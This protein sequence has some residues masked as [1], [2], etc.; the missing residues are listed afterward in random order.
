M[1]SEVLAAIISGAAATAGATTSGIVSGTANRRAYKWTRRLQ[2]YQ[3]QVS[4]DNWNLQNSYNDPSAQMQRY[5]DAGLNPLLIYGDGAGSAGNASGA[6]AASQGQFDDK[7]SR[8]LGNLQLEQAAQSVISS[9]YDTK[10]KQQQVQ[11][12]KI[13]IADQDRAARERLVATD[14]LWQWLADKG[15]ESFELPA[16][17]TS[18]LPIATLRAHP[19]YQTYEQ[20]W[21][22]GEIKIEELRKIVAQSAL[23]GGQAQLVEH[24]L[25]VQGNIDKLLNFDFKNM[26]FGEM[27]RALLGL[28]ISLSRSNNGLGF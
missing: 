7:V 16:G 20:L 4:L 26:S 2:E 12:N 18:G 17:Y 9:Y 24:Q 8:S 1:T 22:Q 23:T 21:K 5:Q 15:E 28:F 25:G 3:N 27:M 13:R 6:P 14:A 10:L 11:E 19:V